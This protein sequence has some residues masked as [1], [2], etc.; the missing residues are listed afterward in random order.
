MN[1]LHCRG[2]QKTAARPRARE[3]QDRRQQRRAETASLTARVDADG[4][5]I[6]VRRVSP[7][8][9]TIQVSA[10]LGLPRGGPS[11]WHSGRKVEE[12]AALAA[13]R[14]RVRLWRNP[15]GGAGD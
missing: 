9:L 12:L 5:E 10:P 7:V 6:E 8:V 13:N 15:G 4:T 2:L 1:V 14:D 11:P 3:R